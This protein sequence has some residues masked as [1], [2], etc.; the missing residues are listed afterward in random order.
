M[1]TQPLRNP[2]DRFACRLGAPDSGGNGLRS[3]VA[4]A[5]A[6]LARAGRCQQERVRVPGR[7]GRSSD[8]FIGPPEMARRRPPWLRS[9]GDREAGARIPNRPRPMAGGFT[10]VELL[11]VLAIVATLSGLL[12]P[13]YMTSRHRAYQATCISNLRQL[14]LAI[15]TYADDWDGHYPYAVDPRKR[16]R[17]V[18]NPDA[19]L[20][21]ISNEELFALPT[22][23]QVL[24]PRLHS[25]GVLRCPADAGMPPADGSPDAPRS[26]FDAWG[27]SYDYND[28]WALKEVTP[29]LPS[30]TP[31][32]WDMGGWHGSDPI[33]GLSN[34]LYA[35]LHVHL[36]D[37]IQ[38]AE[39]GAYTEVLAGPS[40]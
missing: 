37:Y 36:E 14:G 8:G 30:R 17:V 12:F 34:V 39:D 6:T 11:V 20:L 18:E 33:S 7:L 19:N 21:P 2:A 35:D 23:P 40:G 10:L 25:A 15:Q 31:L 22:C 16:A 3:P 4:T 1:T 9:D 5:P 38:L 32:F 13:V 29:K 26:A 24:E 27:T 28:G